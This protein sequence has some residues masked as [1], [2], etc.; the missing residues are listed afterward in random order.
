[1]S[2]IF[3]GRHYNYATLRVEINSLTKQKTFVK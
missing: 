1:M 3:E 2:E